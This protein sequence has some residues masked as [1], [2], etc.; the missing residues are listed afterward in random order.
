M[1]S[2]S[3]LTLV[4]DLQLSYLLREGDPVTIEQAVFALDGNQVVALMPGHGSLVAWFSDKAIR[5]F[6]AN[7][8][9][10]TCYVVGAVDTGEAY[11]EALALIMQINAPEEADGTGRPVYYGELVDHTASGGYQLYQPI[12]HPKRKAKKTPALGYQGGTVN[13]EH[14]APKKGKRRDVSAFDPEDP[15]TALHLAHDH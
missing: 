5:R 15:V 14:K 3:L 12:K 2:R 7:P 8:R 13:I 10:C 4:N 11:G 6:M 9:D 1:K